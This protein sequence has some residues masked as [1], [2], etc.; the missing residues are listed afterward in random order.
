[1]VITTYCFIIM[2]GMDLPA[3]FIEDSQSITFYSLWSEI[4]FRDRRHI[5]CAARNECL[6]ETVKLFQVFGVPFKD[7][8]AITWPL[9]CYCSLYTVPPNSEYRYVSA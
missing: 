2:F 3:S 9:F 4:G 5:V 8:G 7:W 1:M 6:H